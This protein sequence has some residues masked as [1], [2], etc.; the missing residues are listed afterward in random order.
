MWEGAFDHENKKTPISKPA[1]NAHR[2][3]VQA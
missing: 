2:P 1:A 3:N